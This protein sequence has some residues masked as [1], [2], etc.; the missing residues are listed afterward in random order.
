MIRVNL[1]PVKE[2]RRIKKPAGGAAR[3]IEIPVAWIAICIAFVAALSVIAYFH[4][5]SHVKQVAALQEEIHEI[6]QR[7]EELKVPIRKVNEAKKTKEQL[8]RKIDIIKS[9]KAGQTGPVRLMDELSRSM[10]PNLWLTD[11]SEDGTRIQMNGIAFTATP[12]AEFMKNLEQSDVFHSVELTQVSSQSRTGY[13][14]SLKGFQLSC[15]IRYTSG[16][17]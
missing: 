4:H 7:T 2:R 17:R 5:Q 14:N 12:I 9:L 10:P 16:S 13:S 11:M 1:L 15:N 6:E 8:T 3:R